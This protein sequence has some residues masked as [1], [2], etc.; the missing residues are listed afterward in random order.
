MEWE[1]TWKQLENEGQGGLGSYLEEKN[2]KKLSSRHPLLK[3]RRSLLATSIY[4]VIISLGYAFLMYDFPYWQLL[5]GFGVVLTFNIY[6]I[7]KGI[8]LYRNVPGYISGSVSLLKELEEQHEAVSEWIRLQLLAA[9][10][11]YPVAVATGFLLGGML[12]SEKSIEFLMSKPLFGIS[13]VVSVVLFTPLGHWVGRKF[14][15]WS[16]GRHLDNLKKLIDDLRAE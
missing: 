9:R 2:A 12:G 4:G 16:Y 11:V 7:V 10:F 8:K 13:M 1:K 5:L 15:R 14:T 3:I 6:F